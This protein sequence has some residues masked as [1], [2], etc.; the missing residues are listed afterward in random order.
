MPQCEL[1]KPNGERCRARAVAGSGF[2]Y[3]HAPEVAEKRRAACSAGGRTRIKPPPATLPARA[4]KLHLG[5]R[6]KVLR[7]LEDTIHQVRTGQVDVKIANCIG[8][9]LS[10]AVRTFQDNADLNPV[11]VIFNR[12]AIDPNVKSHTLDF[13]GGPME[14]PDDEDHPEPA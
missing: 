1:V 14:L 8:A 10:V 7:L 3:F 11:T 13:A 5:D 9:L 2:C 4:K 6:T 12:P